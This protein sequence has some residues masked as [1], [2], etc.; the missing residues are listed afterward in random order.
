MEKKTLLYYFR[1]HENPEIYNN[2]K[3][4]TSTF[5]LGPYGIFANL[6]TDF[7]KICARQKDADKVKN[8]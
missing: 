4:W 6:G 1:L 8:N 3:N 5:S 2:N 7:V